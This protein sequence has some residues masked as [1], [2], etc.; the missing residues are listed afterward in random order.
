MP[1]TQNYSNFKMVPAVQKTFQIMQALAADN[2]GWMGISDICR[3]IGISKATAHAILTTLKIMG[4]VD[5]SPNSKQY[6]LGARLV[7]LSSAYQNRMGS[8]VNIYNSISADLNIQ[9]NETS[10]M[11]VLEGTDIIYTAKY[12]SSHPLRMSSQVGT[13][14]PAHATGLGKCLLSSYTNE[15]IAQ[16]Y[17]NYTFHPFT[18][19]SITNLAELIRCIEIVRIEGVAY[20]HCEY[21]PDVECI[22]APVRDDTGQIVLAVSLAQPSS[23][24]TPDKLKQEADAIQ[25]AARR[26]SSALGY[27]H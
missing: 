6:A 15:M 11:A 21:W 25:Q 20:D 18:N 5:Q 4:F 26:F 2:N 22:A 17:N 24:L 3:V 13:R 1:Q 8:V 14:L 10:Y 19:N 27:R 16:L 9:F 7:E 12:D 23:R